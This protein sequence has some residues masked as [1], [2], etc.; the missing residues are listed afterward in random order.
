MEMRSGEPS[1]F[2][3]G[4]PGESSMLAFGQLFVTEPS[5]RGPLN[6]HGVV[7]WDPSEVQSQRARNHHDGL[8]VMTHE[9]SFGSGSQ[10]GLDGSLQHLNQSWNRVGA[11]QQQGR[12][13]ERQRVQRHSQLNRDVAWSPQNFEKSIPTE[14]SPAGTE[15][16]PSDLLR[17]CQYYQH[18]KHY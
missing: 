8:G 17:T 14:M 4:E 6:K 11:L 13:N 2:A 10:R 5:W 9:S 16:D 3:L 7:A 1:M 18:Y 12:A 15:Q